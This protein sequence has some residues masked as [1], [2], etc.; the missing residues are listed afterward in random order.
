MTGIWTKILPVGL[1]AFYA[2]YGLLPACTAADALTADGDLPAI[3]LPL[4]EQPPV[5]D[6]VLDDACWQDAARAD[7]FY[8]FKSTDKTDVVRLRMTRDHQWLYLAFE[9]SNSMLEHVEFV[10]TSRD[11]RVQ[12]DECV[13]IY[14]DPGTDGRFYYQFIL[15]A[16]NVQQ[17]IGG[18][19]IS[20]YI[21]WRSA[22]RKL[23][24]RWMAEIALPLSICAG[25]GDPARARINFIY[26]QMNVGLDPYGARI[27]QKQSYY[28]WSPI[29]QSV[30]EPER[31]G[32]LRGLDA[33]PLEAAFLPALD[34]VSVETFNISGDTRYYTVSGF[35]RNYSSV[36]GAV[37]LA[38]EETTESGASNRIT[39]IL[40][41]DAHGQTPFSLKIPVADFVARTVRACLQDR[42]SGET[43][44][45]T[46]ALDTSTLNLMADVTA[47]RNYYTTESEALVRCRLGLPEPELAGM[48]LA[49]RDAQGKIIAEHAAPKSRTDIKFPLAGVAE[50]EHQFSLAL[51][52]RQSNLISQT[53]FEFKKLAPRPGREVKVDKFNHSLVKDGKHIFPFGIC[54][55]GI[56]HWHEE[57]F[58]LIADAGFNLMV[59][60]I[61]G[62][63][64]PE[65]QAAEYMEL[66]Q[67]YGLMVAE[68]TGVQ[69]PPAPDKTPEEKEQLC[70]EYYQ[71]NWP[72]IE[73]DMRIM[74]EYPNL[75]MYFNVD[76]PNLINPDMRY[77]VSEY[78]YRD[79]VAIDP[80]HPVYTVYSRYFTDDP[81]ALKIADVI[82]FDLYV[83]PGW[84]D[85]TFDPVK[86]IAKYTADL[87]DAARKHQKAMLIMP[88]TQGQDPVRAPLP[89]S[90]GDQK[91]QIYAA[92]IYGAKG[93]IYFSLNNVWAAEMWSTLTELARQI[94]T[95][96]PALLAPEPE[97]EIVYNPGRFDAVSLQFPMVHARLFQH[98]D[99]G[100]VLLAVSGAE[101]PVQTEFVLTGL[102]ADVRVARMFGEKQ[103]LAVCD[104]C[105]TDEIEPYGTRAYR[106]ESAALAEPIQLMLNMQADETRREP[107]PLLRPIIAKIEKQKNYM[108]N[109]V[110]AQ[111]SV[112]EQFPDFIRPFMPNLPNLGTPESGWFLDPDNAWRG[113][114]SLCMRWT[115][116]FAKFKWEPAGSWDH[117]RTSTGVGIHNKHA[118]AFSGA[119]LVCYPADIS[120]PAKRVFSFY[121]KAA[122]DGDQVRVFIGGVAGENFTL[123]TK[124]QRYH[125]SVTM[126]PVSTWLPGQ[127]I[128]IRHLPGSTVW[129]NGLQMEDGETP[130]EFEINN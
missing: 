102:G 63:T 45:N 53:T 87:R 51:E 106:I 42:A 60:T 127:W 14:L 111:R 7:D 57:S 100:Y 101:S 46:G 110:F 35:A 20:W 73:R 125:F 123:T 78:F 109:P 99:G 117:V 83:K 59:R 86:L 115:E 93:I 124:W 6:G 64:M 22:T 36:T 39:E 2:L 27:S 118:L 112:Y 4:T 107:R 54:M 52:D 126:Q 74:M 56:T 114:P 43:L 121:A 103:A 48:R 95:L 3:T 16:N 79:A 91:A 77:L 104:H 90:P 88:I 62:Y 32:R 31:F 67:K 97:Q 61:H 21:P 69:P 17:E 41:L 15:T 49:V 113:H 122:K 38:V 75:L 108:P 94:Q 44:A 80:Y 84:G 81:R 105:F 130:T 58:E 29:T 72:G 8:V 13:E 71:K 19:D 11:D 128:L 30:H 129:I 34:Q 28:I 120:T 26:Y 65:S 9:L 23:S 89:I 47:N 76:E 119:E 92:L 1:I 24:D 18:R 5:I 12:R 98:P 96:A 85:Y 50:G 68:W 10:A 82:I 40:S 55:H 70:H 66:A 33:A 37:D 116:P 25:Y